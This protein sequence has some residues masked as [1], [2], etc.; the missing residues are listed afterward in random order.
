MTVL[1]N[2]TLFIIIDIGHFLT[3]KPLCVKT[4]TNNCEIIVN[5]NNHMV[6]LHT[7]EKIT[8][9]KSNNQCPILLLKCDTISK[10]EIKTPQ[11]ALS[12]HVL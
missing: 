11:H 3:P 12:A 2:M 9:V 4:N 5:Y 8:V 10:D 1:N 7:W 6:F